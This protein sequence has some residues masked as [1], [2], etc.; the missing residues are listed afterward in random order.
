MKK[1]ILIS[2]IVFLLILVVLTFV[3]KSMYNFNLPRVTAVRADSGYVPLIFKTIGTLEFPDSETIKTAGEWKISEVLIEE[4][5]EVT[6]GDILCCF[7]TQASDIE[8]DSLRLE[9][10]KLRSELNVLNR[11]PERQRNEQLR[12]P[13]VLSAELALAEA[14]LD[15]ALS[16]APPAEGLPAPVSGLIYGFS[17]KEGETVPAGE[18]LLTIITDFST[19]ELRF[20]IPAGDGEIFT[21]GASVKALVGMGVFDKAAGEQLFERISVSGEVVRGVLRED[22]WECVAEMQIP[23]YGGQPVAFQD[24]PVTVTHVGEMHNY[25]VPVDCLF[26]VQDFTVV[27]TI[28]QRQ[29]LFGEESFLRQVRVNVLFDNGEYA[30]LEK[31]TEMLQKDTMLAMR[32]SDAIREGSV[33][34]VDNDS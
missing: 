1:K 2:A 27:Y 25:I 20:F 12:G 13:S 11:L 14:R 34:W 33:V 7:D 31:G 19:A 26:Y 18:A 8:L 23:V 9:I 32:P 17:A 28:L 5:G 6:E 30:V 15:Y 21:P 16:Q 22:R 3:S 29:G 10:E 4:G 24:I